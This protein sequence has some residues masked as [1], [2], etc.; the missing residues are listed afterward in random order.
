[1]FNTRNKQQRS[2][3]DW[4]EKNDT[5]RRR[6]DNTY[7]KLFFNVST[8]YELDDTGRLLRHVSSATLPPLLHTGPPSPVVTTNIYRQRLAKCTGSV[9]VVVADAVEEGRN[10]KRFGFTTQPVHMPDRR[11]RCCSSVHVSAGSVNNVKK[12]RESGPQPA[13]A[14][15]I[16]WLRLRCSRIV[17]DSCR[18]LCGKENSIQDFPHWWIKKKR[19]TE[20]FAPFKFNITILHWHQFS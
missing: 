10:W 1:M 14:L 3:D 5:R 17:G 6:S 7:Q 9:A 20:Y 8:R 18:D 2:A 13:H 4:T 15:T 19:L 12:G 16:A 11:V